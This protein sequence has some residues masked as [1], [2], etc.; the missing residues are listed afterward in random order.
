MD[1]DISDQNAASVFRTDSSC[2]A[3]PSSHGVTTQKIA[4]GRACV[5][6][7]SI[8]SHFK[9]SVHYYYSCINVGLILS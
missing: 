3:F 7:S 2:Y 8:R 6:I 1:I 9:K 5:R 4:M